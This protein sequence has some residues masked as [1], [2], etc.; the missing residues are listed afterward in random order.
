M[1]YMILIRVLEL[2]PFLRVFLL[3]ESAR[4]DEVC[5]LGFILKK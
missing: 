1:N 2:H 4:T 3:Y 5:R